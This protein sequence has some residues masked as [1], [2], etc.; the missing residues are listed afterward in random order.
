MT[1]AI[2]VDVALIWFAEP[3]VGAAGKAPFTLPVVL[4]TAHA[5]GTIPAGKPGVSFRV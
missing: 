4:F 3:F 1:A 2:E 5:K